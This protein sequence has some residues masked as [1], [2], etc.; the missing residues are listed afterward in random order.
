LPVSFVSN[1]AIRII[2]LSKAIH[3]VIFPLSLVITAVEINESAN[4]IFFII[5][6]ETLKFTFLV[7]LNCEYSSSSSNATFQGF[8]LWLSLIFHLWNYFAFRSIFWL[9][10]E[11][12]FAKFGFRE[13]NY[14]F[15][16][17]IVCDNS[18]RVTVEFDRNFWFLRR[19]RSQSLNIIKIKIADKFIWILIRFFS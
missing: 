8:Y 11:L 19:L 10:R 1:S 5:W 6:F 15:I 14:F 3:S 17:R 2:Q 13:L 4:S 16:L 18:E 9:I 12:N 7:I